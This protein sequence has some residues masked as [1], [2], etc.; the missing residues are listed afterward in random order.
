MHKTLKLAQN[1]KSPSF[2][3]QKL[4]KDYIGCRLMYATA[5]VLMG[6]TV[7]GPGGSMIGKVLLSLCHCDRK[8]FKGLSR[9]IQEACPYALQAMKVQERIGYA[10]LHCQDLQIMGRT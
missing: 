3:P 10:K 9:Y 1:A 7:G 4:H 2:L 6:S 5:R 8:C